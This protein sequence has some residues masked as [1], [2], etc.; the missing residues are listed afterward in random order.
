MGKA[1]VYFH[2]GYTDIIVCMALLDYYKSKYEHITV[3]V[4]ADAK[5]MMDYYLQWKEGI[6]PVYFDS[7]DGRYYGQVVKSPNEDKVVYIRG[8]QKGYGTVIVPES[9]KMMCHGEHDKWREDETALRWYHYFITNKPLPTDTAKPYFTRAFYHYYNVPYITRV[10][11]FN[12]NRDLSLEEK[13]YSEFVAEHGEDYV[14]YHDD[15]QRAVGQ[16]LDLYKP[17]KINF[18]NKLPDTEYV[19]LHRQ[20]NKFFDYIKIIQNAKEIH[21]ID[22]VWATLIYQLKAKY[23]D[24]IKA[25]VTIYCQRGHYEIFKDPVQLDWKLV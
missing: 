25:P 5:E 10:S 17:T 4:R 20:T 16:E 22:S 12:V 23:P 11:E 21:L 15:Q 6:T 3:F 7:D 18:E 24:M 2:Q 9:W 8:P 13:A 14:L 1:F 19:N